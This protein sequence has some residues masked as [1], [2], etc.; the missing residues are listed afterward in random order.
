MRLPERWAAARRYYAVVA[1]RK[2]VRG[3]LAGPAVAGGADGLDM[4]VDGL[5]TSR[6]DP[7]TIAGNIA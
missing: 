4:L 3:Q 2:L 6:L 1:L 5:L 7:V